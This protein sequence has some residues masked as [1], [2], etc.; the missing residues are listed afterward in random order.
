MSSEHLA[1]AETVGFSQMSLP[2]HMLGRGS[3]VGP[4][5][6]LKPLGRGGVGAVYHAKVVE[7]SAL[8]VGREVALKILRQD[9]LSESDLR[10]FTREAAY[11]QAFEPPESVVFMIWVII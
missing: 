2:A 9:N 8:S 6:I 5:E 1:D 11:L 10:R 7:S 4:Y 3:R